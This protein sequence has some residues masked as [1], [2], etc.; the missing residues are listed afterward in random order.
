MSAFQKLGEILQD[1]QETLLSLTP[2]GMARRTTSGSSPITPLF[3]FC[4][5]AL[6]AAVSLGVFSDIC[7]LQAAAFALFATTLVVSFCVYLYCLSKRPDLLRSESYDLEI[8]KTS[9]GGKGANPETVS[10]PDSGAEGEG[11]A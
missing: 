11:G 3:F 2:G 1:L 5:F 10:A 9:P 4:F 8:R 7:W 6:V